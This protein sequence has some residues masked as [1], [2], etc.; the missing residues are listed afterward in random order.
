M[1]ARFNHVE[2]ID[3]MKLRLIHGT[4]RE[5]FIYFHFLG[6][7]IQNILC[8]IDLPQLTPI[9]HLPTI[10][11]SY[12]VI[13]LEN[14][15]AREAAIPT[16]LLISS[17]PFRPNLLAIQPPI[18]PPTMP[19]MANIETTIAYIKVECSYVIF[20]PSFRRR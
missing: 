2:L 8:K 9:R 14:T 6:H 5:K 1:K 11:N 16:I 17:P 13:C 7:P 3:H 20:S 19:P 4:Y 15:I 18:K 12:E 10:N